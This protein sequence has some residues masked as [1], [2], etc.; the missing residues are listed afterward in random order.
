MIRPPRLQY[1]DTIA[2][3]SPAKAIEEQHIVFAKK[4]LENE[5][6]NVIVGQYSTGNF[7]YF[8]GTDQERTADLQWAIDHPEVKAIICSRGGYG[9]IRILE[10]IQWAA[11][12]REPKWLVGFSDITIFHAQLLKLGV[13]SIHA[14]MPLNFQE[15][16]PAAIS[17]LLEVLTTEKSVVTTWKTNENNKNGTA[18][19]ELIGGNLSILYSL[20]SSPI[21]PDFQG[22][23]LFIEDVGEQ[24]YHIDRMLYSLKYKGVFEQISGL[25]IGGMTDMK[26][27][28]KP[29]GWGI[30]ELILNQL[31]YTK[32]PVAFDFPCGHIDDNRAVVSG[33]MSKLEIGIS[34][35]SLVQ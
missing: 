35:V 29:I 26:D 30:E 21:C 5:G 10:A 18:K 22:K 8:S 16:S 28:L 25:I 2:I 12:L 24:L 1:G 6:Y 11:I 3:V 13:E 20:L 7:N 27:T 14:T 34:S 33:R 31:E 23:I 4:L 19:G 32:I 15:N 9:S 17:T